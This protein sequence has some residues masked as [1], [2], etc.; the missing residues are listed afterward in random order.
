MKKVKITLIQ[1]DLQRGSIPSDYRSITCL[2]MMQKILTAQIMEEIY[3]LLY[4]GLFSEEYCKG[5]GGKNEPIG[6]ASWRERE[7]WDGENLMGTRDRT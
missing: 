6:R 5:T 4:R 2:S 7:V 3:L 1:K